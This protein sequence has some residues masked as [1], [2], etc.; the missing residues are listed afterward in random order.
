VLSIAVPLVA[1]VLGGFYFFVYRDGASWLRGL[2]D[3]K[4]VPVTGRVFLGDEPMSGGQIQTQL[5]GSNAKGSMAFPDKDGNFTLKI[6][7]DGT[8]VDGAFAGKHKVTVTKTDMGQAPSPGAQ[9]AS[10]TPATYANFAETPLEIVVDAAKE[11]NYFELRIEKKA[12]EAGG[13]RPGGFPAGPPPGADAGMSEGLQRLDAD[14]N[15]QISAE[16]AGRASRPLAML[17][18]NSDADKDGVLDAAEFSAAVAQA[19]SPNRPATDRPQ[20][21]SESA[22]PESA[23]PGADDAPDKEAVESPQ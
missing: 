23:A 7:V 11:K 2:F 15:G 18:A 21:E 4:L 3:P 17:L 6:D 19:G 9:P 16:E 13:G 14:G 1:V 10:L 20:L 12:E 22:G 5:V 8:F